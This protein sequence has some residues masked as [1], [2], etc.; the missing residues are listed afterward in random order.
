MNQIQVIETKILE[1][2]T[3]LDHW[4]EQITKHNTTLTQITSQL[5]EIKKQLK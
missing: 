3:L 2:R 4:T 5:T 1:I